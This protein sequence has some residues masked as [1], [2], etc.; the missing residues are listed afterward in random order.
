MKLR[1]L[2]VN[3]YRDES[4]F[5][6]GKEIL[7]VCGERKEAASDTSGAIGGNVWN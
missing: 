7:G 6:G 4:T 5:E 1:R 3:V 2:K